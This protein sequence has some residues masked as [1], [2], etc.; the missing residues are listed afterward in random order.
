MKTALIMINLF[1]VFVCL[2]LGGITFAKIILYGVPDRLRAWEFREAARIKIPI[3]IK[4]SYT[5]KWSSIRKALNSNDAILV[6]QA[7]EHVRRELFGYGKSRGHLLKPED[8]FFKKSEIYKNAGKTYVADDAIEVHILSPRMNRYFIISVGKNRRSGIY[9]RLFRAMG[10]K[11]EKEMY[12]IYDVNPS[13]IDERT[14]PG[15]EL[16]APDIYRDIDRIVIKEGVTKGYQERTIVP[17]KPFSMRIGYQ[18]RKFLT[19]EEQKEFNVYEWKDEKQA[20]ERTYEKYYQFYL[21][22][23]ISGNL[24]SGRVTLMGGALYSL[25][26]EAAKRDLGPVIANRAEFDPFTS[27]RIYPETLLDK[28]SQYVHLVK[29]P[30]FTRLFYVIFPGK[31][32]WKEVL[33]ESIN[34]DQIMNGFSEYSLPSE[35][36]ISANDRTADLL[37]VCEWI[38]I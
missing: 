11:G 26:S 3:R 23:G 12:D 14:L 7:P 29:H 9:H 19:E 1:L 5:K 16:P 20:Y 18:H 28:S 10:Y 30:Y 35:T 2:I 38:R 15:E 22:R 24:V 8:K 25:A 13:L 17:I 33:E 31:F 37:L 32:P 36:K 4:F 21:K 6:V 27:M 34:S